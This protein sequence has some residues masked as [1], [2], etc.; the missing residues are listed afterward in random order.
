MT[1]ASLADLEP[2][3]NFIRRHIGPSESETSNMLREVGATS[4]EDFI[5]K[6]VPEKIRIAKPLDLPK[7]KAE[8]T[9]LS[10]LRKMS[11][12]NE[13]FI[14]M[15]GMGYYGTVTPKVILRNVLENPGWY[16]AYTPYQAEV[17]QGRLEALLN[18]QQAV[19]DLTGLELTNASL[20]DEA[21]AAAE[22]MA[23]AKRVVKTTANTFFIDSDTHP[24]TIGVVQTRAAAFG[25]DV[26]IGDPAKDLKPESVFAA[27]LSYPGSSG[28]IR[29]YRA[30][31]DKLHGTGALAIMATDLLALA[32]LTPPGEL[33]ADVAIGSTQRFG[34]PMGYG[35]PHADTLPR[36]AAAAI[37]KPA[38][39]PANTAIIAA[40]NAWNT[41]ETTIATAEAIQLGATLSLHEK[42]AALTRK[43]DAETNSILE[44]WDVTILGLVPAGSALYTVLLPHGRETLTAGSLDEQ[45]DAIRDFA[46]RLALQSSKPTLVSLGQHRT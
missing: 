35:G 28:E 8:R 6:V 26:V 41:G 23:M 17:S 2:G 19:I 11:D 3:S 9:A 21:T 12:R 46:A 43:P 4:L 36:I 30:I 5:N 27:L 39:A 31:I 18:F 38:L 33:G 22:A 44:G 15:I 24:Q 37:L 32:L 45:I 14:S 25:Y 29:D 7:A 16:T 13:V 10:Y 34:V 40:S 1:R 20:L 42:M